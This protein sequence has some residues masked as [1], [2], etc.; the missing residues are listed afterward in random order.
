MPRSFS[1][2]SLVIASHNSGKI[3]EIKTLLEPFR[4]DVRSALDYPLEE[5]EETET[6][7]TGNAAIKS[8]YFAKHTGLP[9]LADDS[10]L[11]VEQLDGEPGVYSA[12]WAGEKK[13]FQHAMERV[14]RELLSRG[15]EPEGQ[16]AWFICV[17]SLTWPDGET[18]Q[19]EGRVAGRLTFP[20]RGSH[21]FGY[22][23]I[24]I[25]EGFSQTFAE[26]KPEEKHAIS[27]RA[28]AFEK[29]IENCF[30]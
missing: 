14:R 8:K 15:L 3:R 29:L 10:G 5:P 25:P 6:T 11:S 17:L 23:P 18:E 21:G 27:H 16:K 30:L 22:D 12:R 2:S 9:A 7:F 4:V 1:E 19:V 26:M 13:D 28:R 20:P 24:F